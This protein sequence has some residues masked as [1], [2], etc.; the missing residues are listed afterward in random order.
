MATHESFIQLGVPGNTKNKKRVRYTVPLY[1]KVYSAYQYN[2]QKYMQIYRKLHELAIR[3][4]NPKIFWN[5]N[6]YRILDLCYIKNGTKRISLNDEKH[7]FR[8]RTLQE[9]YK[10][11][12]DEVTNHQL[13]LD[14]GEWKLIK[15]GVVVFFDSEFGNQAIISGSELLSISKRVKMHI[16]LLRQLRQGTKLKKAVKIAKRK[17]KEIL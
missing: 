13:K 8:L 2:Q 1:R 10:L 9:I 6:P 7:I 16:T 5:V 12:A 17:A 15:S 4:E 14:F 11:I 3:L